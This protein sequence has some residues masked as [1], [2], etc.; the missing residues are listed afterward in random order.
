MNLLVCTCFLWT[1]LVLSRVHGNKSLIKGKL[2]RGNDAGQIKGDHMQKRIYRSPIGKGAQV[3]IRLM[4][5]VYEVPTQS[6]N[7][8]KYIKYGTEKDAILDF[9][10]TKPGAYKVRKSRAGESVTDAYIG[11][12]M[13]RLNTRDRVQGYRPTITLKTRNEKINAKIVYMN[14]RKVDE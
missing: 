13:I 7:Y 14:K 3:I 4:Q 11:H 8:K 9:W 10:S 12:T 5:N 6:T 2:F 1:L